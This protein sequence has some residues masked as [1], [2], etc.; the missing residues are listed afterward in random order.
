MA[1]PD[2]RFEGLVAVVTGSSRGFGLAIAQRLSAGGASLV[3]VSRKEPALAEAAA[4]LVGP[5]TW[6]ALSVREQGAADRVIEATV[7]R[8]GSVDILVNNAATNPYFGPLIGI[9]DAQM[10]TTVET[11]LAAP[12]RW[13]RAA[14]DYSMGTSGGSVLNVCSIGGMIVEPNIGFYNA[15]KAALLH[16]TR[17]LAVELAPRV[18]VN[19]IA[20][21]LVRTDMA[22]ALLDGRETQLQADIPL[23]RVGEPGDVART[24][25]FL[26]D[27]ANAWITGTCVIVDGGYIL[28]RP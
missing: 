11:N 3:L 28:A 6:H 14:W 18:R 10:Q 9:S 20:P 21:G 27:P 12:L 2:S 1:P 4:T 7:E 24:A 25:E 22:Q 16:L 13:T 5:V 19:A 15:T 26:V 23:Q 17:Q 8:F